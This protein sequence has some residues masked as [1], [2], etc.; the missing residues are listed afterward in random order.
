MHATEA[1]PGKVPPAGVGA[2][3]STHFVPF[4]SSDRAIRSGAL[5]PPPTAMQKLAERQ[6]TPRRLTFVPE[7]VGNP[8]QAEPDQVSA[9]GE[10]PAVREMS[11][12]T[13]TQLD[14]D[15]QE[16]PAGAKIRE[17][18]KVPRR[19]ELP[20]HRAYSPRGPAGEEP[21][22]AVRQKDEDAQER[23]LT[24][25]SP[26]P[27]GATG[28]SSDQACPPLDDSASGSKK[29]G[30][31]AM[32]GDWL[33]AADEPTATQVAVAHETAESA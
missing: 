10:A 24:K 18:A 23:E 19:Q 22:P 2:V 5:P 29:L 30:E 14:A 11:W 15:L 7:G 33:D 8:A 1:R 6:S 21:S 9:A 16:M 32:P 4:Q 3:L 28:S 27:V 26:V 17:E 31:P 20:F 12:P 25:L 13:A